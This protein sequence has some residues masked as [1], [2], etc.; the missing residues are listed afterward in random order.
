VGRLLHRLRPADERGFTLVE[1]VVVCVLL[2]VVI[3]GVS[4][5]FISGSH[6]ELN[7]NDR[8]QAQQD[9]RLVMNQLRLDVHSACAANVGSSGGTFPSGSMLTLAYVPSGDPTQCGASSSSQKVIWCAV[10]SPTTPGQYA[11]Y[12]ST[13]S[14]C[15][16]SAGKLES[17][18]LSS[19]ALFS[20]GTTI[21]VGQLQT[22]QATVAVSLQSGQA[23]A[24]YALAQT[25][26]LRNAV[27][28]S[29]DAST[30]CPATA[31]NTTCATGTCPSGTGTSCYPPVIQ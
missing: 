6:V 2:A 31:D 8:F 20:T 11:V 14:P 26:A 9:A 27:Y 19:S 17:D 21:P 15:S 24:P 3:A 29:T 5:V 4:T 30:S 7:L 18:N 23:G 12:R 28:Q 10:A 16:A 1:M 22:I 25:L 13:S